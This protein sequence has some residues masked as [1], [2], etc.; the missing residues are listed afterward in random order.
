MQSYWVQD[1][2]I[3]ASS[4]HDVFHDPG[5]ARLHG[6]GS[7]MPLVQDANQFL[8]I[9]FKDETN[10]SAVAVQGHPNYEY[11]VT[12]Y[13]LSFSVDGKAWDELSEVLLDTINGIFTVQ[14]PAE[15]SRGIRKS[16]PNFPCLENNLNAIGH[17]LSCPLPLFQSEVKC[18]GF[19]MVMGSCFHFAGK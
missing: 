16:S 9:H 5:Q 2:D 17:F 8:Q 3:T 7:W 11:W 13:S 14:L 12:K 6:N 19:D 10:V 15:G 1:A 4:I 18:E